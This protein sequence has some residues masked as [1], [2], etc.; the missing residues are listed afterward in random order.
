MKYTLEEWAVYVRVAD[1]LG[2][3]LKAWFANQPYNESRTAKRSIIFT[4]LFLVFR[5]QRVMTTSVSCFASDLLGAV[6]MEA[7]SQ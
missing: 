1:F 3:L 6:S 4:S 7:N 5:L 2:L